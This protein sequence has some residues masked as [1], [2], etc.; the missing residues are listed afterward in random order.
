MKRFVKEFADYEIQRMARNEYLEPEFVEER[1]EEILKI[2]S[3]CEY[4]L[5][6]ESEAC[7]SIA[8]KVR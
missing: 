2:V 8:N 4:G 7:W 6:S 3:A 1:A 5:I